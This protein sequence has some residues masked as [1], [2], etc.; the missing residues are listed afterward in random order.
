MHARARPTTPSCKLQTTTPPRP[1]VPL[2]ALPSSAA[3]LPIE[4]AKAGRQRHPARPLL[5]LLLALVS[6]L[7]AIELPRLAWLGCALV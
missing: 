6:L 1:H 3:R 2:R 5:L 4:A 7:L